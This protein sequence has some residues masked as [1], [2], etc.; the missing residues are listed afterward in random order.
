MADDVTTNPGSGG[1]RFAADDIGGTHHLR[2][3]VQQGADG[4][5]TDVSTAAPLPAQLRNSGGTEIGTAAAPVRVDPT[6]TT[7]Q[8]ITDGGGSITVDAASLP[9]P[10]GASTEA[11][12]SSVLT[13]VSKIDD[14]QGTTGSAVP[15]KGNLIQGSDGT[16]ARNVKTDSAG[17]LQV[18]VLT[19][20]A[21]ATGDNAIG[22]VKIT[23]GSEVASVDASNRLEV[24][25]GNTVSVSDGAGTLT[26]DAPVGAPVNVQVG[27]GTRTA[28]VRDTGS[29][30]SLNVSI[31]DA[32]GN[33][34][35]S[36]GGSGGTAVADDSAFTPAV[37]EITP[38]GGTY[39]SS[40]DQVNDNDAGAFAMTQSR[41]LLTCVET[42]NGD[43]AMDDTNDAV[44]V[45]IVAGSSSG[46]EY[47][48]DAASAANP[49]GGQVM[50]RRRDSLSTET[51][52]DG[53][54]TALNS[55]GK[56]ELYVKHVDSIPVTDNGGSL[57]V[58]ASSLPLPTGAAT[59]ATLGDVKTAVQ[60]IDDAVATDGSATPT[61]AILIAGQDG[62]N[63]QSLK[64]DSSG[65]VAVTDDGTTISI[66]D[67]AGSITVDGSV[68]V[69]S[70][71]LPSGAATEAKQDTQ[72]TALQ[73]IDDI[74]KT[75]DAAFAPATDKVAMVGAE[76]DDDTPDSVN[77]GD[78]GALRM[79]A[80][81]N[82]YVRLR[83][84]AGNE[85]GMNVDASGNANVIAA[86][87]SGVDIGD[88][89][90]N[91][92]SG[93][94][95]VNIQDGGNS[96]TV[97]GTVTANAG[98]GPFPVSD[99]S[100]S[101]TVDAPSG[102][103]VHVQI[104]DGTRQATV[105]DTGSA[106]SLNVAI[107]DGSGN[108]ITSFGGGTQYTEDAASASDPVGNQ[109]LARRRDSLSSE[110]TTDGDVTAINSTAKGELYVKHVDAIPVTDNAGSITV[111][112]GGT[113]AVQSTIAA[114]ATNIAKAE[115]AASAS[116]D[117]GVPAMA[118]RKATPANT[119][120]T[121]GDYEMIQMS[122]GRVWVSA[123]VDAALPAGTNAIGKLAA[124]NGVDIGDVDVTSVPSDPFGAN[125]DA[126]SASGSISA[127]LRFIASSGIPIGSVLPATGASNLGKAEDA[128]HSSGD[129]GVMALAV[130]NEANAARAADGDYV[131]IATDTE[132]NVRTVGNRDHDAVDA[133]EPVKVG[134]K[135]IAHGSNPSAVAAADRTDL[136]ANR[137]GVLF[138]IGGHPNIVTFEAAYTAAQT[139]TA[140]VSVSSGTKIVVTEIE[141][142]CDHAN[143]VDVGVRVGFGTANT[144]TTTG[145]VLTHPGIAP[146]SGVV[147]GSG[148]GILGIGGDG[149]DLRITC[150]VP[151]T[152]SIRIIVS[153]YTI[154]S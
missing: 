116:A 128:A 24:A 77:E 15:S 93:G 97:D 110:T 72:I 129:V 31:V 92:G 105:R 96:I 125:A 65:R 123:T 145:V 151:T 1:A 114:G 51:T 60:L 11:T 39:R 67:G 119:S 137:H 30:D 148:A 126:A 127:K 84:N 108:Q 140:I 132:G 17:E 103:P 74:V 54:V 149:E 138:T 69:S 101:L 76:F 87:N 71:A 153:Y 139:D 28:T 142:L 5:A 136:Y 52:T 94:S 120:D 80:N 59:E 102:T 38:V 146:G 9:L 3:K 21:I 36:F 104:G 75:D 143:T 32:S 44:R 47:T 79:S 109:I 112:N 8:P 147:R 91:N 135:A 37:T 100:G 95:A 64:T 42:P 111:D 117:V 63:A 83:D 2:V 7:S 86:A 14:V 106:D 98:S 10:S 4:S 99:N 29:S 68:S 107:V 61:K 12:Q 82:L 89:T 46:T 43:S 55:T 40:R 49:A 26:V 22:R 45:N 131:P 122:A 58:D 144:P 121:D 25:V 50:A 33:Q 90:I 41:A 154:E 130:S 133:G 115:D 81:R 78:A 16:N 70:S 6:G 57:T 113:F 13:E 18:D 85:R 134:A 56:G 88:V 62:T 19:A 73:I 118:I 124:N 53:D 27:D 34:I 23:D 20:P 141:A 35:T 66:D 150:E 48:E 152:G